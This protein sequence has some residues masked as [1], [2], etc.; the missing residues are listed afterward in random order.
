MATDRDALLARLE[1]LE[2]AVAELRAQLAAAPPGRM[3]A[4]R[5]TRRCPACGGGALLHFRNVRETVDG[6][7]LAALGLTH[8][9]G[10]LSYKPRAPL[11]AFACRACNLVEWHVIEFENVVSDGETIIAIDPEPAPPK[12]GPFR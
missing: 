9:E 2:A 11:E 4:M 7:D 3:R 10:W 5:D 8:E 1:T 12:T 6:G